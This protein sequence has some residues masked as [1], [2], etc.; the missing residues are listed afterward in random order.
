MRMRHRLM[1]ALVIALVGILTI[2]L[3]VLAFGGGVGGGS[4]FGGGSSGGG[5]SGG[6]GG[7]SGG[8]GGFGFPMFFPFLGF[9]GG[10]ILPILIL[11]FFF[12]MNRQA[13]ASRQSGG[14][15]LP[16]RSQD[17]NVIRLELALLATATDV[18]QSLHHLVEV[19][20]TSSP[21]G[22]SNL[23]QQS[24]LLLLRNQQY[25]HAAS[26]S[27]QRVRYAEA[28]SVF[29]SLTVQARSRLSFEAITN[30]NGSRQID[31][32]HLP[33][34]ANSIPPG[35]YVVVALV[36]ASSAPLRL[37]QARTSEEIREQ[38]AEVAAAAGSDLEAVEVIWQPDRSGEALSRD[39]LLS[40]YPEMA[41][42]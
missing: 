4:S 6:G 21:A 40:L 19:T 16:T 30:V 2:A 8:G 28:E 14:S 22:L 33:S 11:L 7:F 20:D 15:S 1:L 10:G 5:F 12:W 9:G 42:I 3:P 25:W 29:N 24:G 27:F 17:V 31:T 39:D 36:V 13:S 23:L 35:D 37:R 34:P 18:P 32:A 41:P 38:I 26:Y